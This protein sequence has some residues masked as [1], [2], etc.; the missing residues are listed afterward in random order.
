MAAYKAADRRRGGQRAGG[1]D[2]RRRRYPV[3]MAWRQFIS[4]PSPGGPGDLSF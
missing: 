2:G 3:L 1:K 4:C